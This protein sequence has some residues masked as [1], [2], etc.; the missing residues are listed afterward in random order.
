MVTV[1]RA[2]SD[3]LQK[4]WIKLDERQ[5]QVENDRSESMN[6]REGSS[7]NRQIYL[8]PRTTLGPRVGHGSVVR[9][10][11]PSCPTTTISSCSLRRLADPNELNDLTNRLLT[12]FSSIINDRSR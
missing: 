6:S 1:N 4:V 5:D 12:S 11:A 10:S 8:L 3:D 7:I 9:W 2:L